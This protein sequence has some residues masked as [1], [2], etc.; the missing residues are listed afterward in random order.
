MSVGMLRRAFAEQW[1]GYYAGYLDATGGRISEAWLSARWAEPTRVRGGW[2][3]D[4]LSPCCSAVGLGG[5]MQ[6]GIGPSVVLVEE[7]G[8]S[9]RRRSKPRG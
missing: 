2:S 9:P 6:I 3:G 7:P 1:G 8:H 5:R 4:A